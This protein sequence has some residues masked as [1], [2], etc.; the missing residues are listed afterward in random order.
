MFA[1]NMQEFLIFRNLMDSI[2]ISRRKETPIC[3]LFLE[4]PKLLRHSNCHQCRS[5]NIN[6]RSNKDVFNFG[7]DDFDKGMSRLSELSSM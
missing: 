7:F 3:V 2:S 5:W 4:Y 6:W 1:T